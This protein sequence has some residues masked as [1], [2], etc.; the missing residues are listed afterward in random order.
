MLGNNCAKGCFIYIA[1]FV[2][3]VM[4]STMGLSG[5]AA[6]FGA[7]EVQGNKPEVSAMTAGGNQ[8]APAPNMASITAD[9]AAVPDGRGGGGVPTPA[10]EPPPPVSQPQPQPQ[11]QPTSA[12]PPPTQGQGGSITGEV[13]SPFYIVQGG[14][15]LWSISRK[16]GVDLDTL[17]SKNGIEDDM[18]HPDDLLYLPDASQPA[19]P[20]APPASGEGAPGASNDPTIPA[21][22]N[23]GITTRKP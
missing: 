22:P 11:V 19:A 15:S 5:L 14:D 13:S 21:M 9:G 3:L 2:L 8:P 18:I 12:P 6:K 4:V 1:A 20:S 10:S 17:R 23:T 16:F 7:A